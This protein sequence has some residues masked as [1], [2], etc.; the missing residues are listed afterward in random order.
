[1]SAITKLKEGMTSLDEIVRATAP[2]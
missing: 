2:D 1:M